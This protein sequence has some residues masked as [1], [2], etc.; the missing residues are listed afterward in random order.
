[1]RG[2]PFVRLAAPVPFTNSLEPL[3]ETSAAPL[4]APPIT[5][6][7]VLTLRIP[8]SASVPKL[9]AAIGKLVVHC[10]ARS[11]DCVGGHVR[12]SSALIPIKARVPFAVTAVTIPSVGG[13]GPRDR[14]E[15]ESKRQQSK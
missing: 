1:M 10:N 9:P 12:R 14:A 15:G 5:N 6:P 2:P 4:P 7:L 3:L 11:D 13:L 8:L